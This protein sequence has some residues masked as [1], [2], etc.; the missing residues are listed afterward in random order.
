ME[1]IDLNSPAPDT[2]AI[3]LAALLR[4]AAAQLP[5][6]GFSA[7]VLAALPPPAAAPARGRR[8]AAALGATAGCVFVAWRG[9]AW[10]DVGAALARLALAVDHV[11]P[12][13]SPPQIFAA[14]W[15]TAVSLIFAFWSE[16][17]RKLP[18]Q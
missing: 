3:R 4:D 13:L 16:L 6:D 8:L 7:R 15:V 10:S 14:L 5:D 2:E 11:A 12:A 1:P 17:R 18:L 9:L